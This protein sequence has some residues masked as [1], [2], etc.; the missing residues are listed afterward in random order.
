[1]FLATMLPPCDGFGA[2]QL[3]PEG[4]DLSILALGEKQAGGLRGTAGAHEVLGMSFAL[5]GSA[6]PDPGVSPW[7]LALESKA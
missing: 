7:G 4:P 2:L 1:M 6:P 5:L 3:T